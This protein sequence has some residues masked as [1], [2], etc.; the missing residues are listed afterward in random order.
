MAGRPPKAAMQVM[1]GCSCRYDPRL[2]HKEGHSINLYLHEIVDA[3]YRGV[4]ILAVIF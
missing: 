1:E 2:E 4:G 3:S